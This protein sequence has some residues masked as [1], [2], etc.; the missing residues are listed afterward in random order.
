MSTKFAVVFRD[1]KEEKECMDN[2]KDYLF[3][4]QCAIIFWSTLL[5]LILKKWFMNFQFHFWLDCSLLQYKAFVSQ[6]IFLCPKLSTGI[7]FHLLLKFARP[8]LSNFVTLFQ[9][10]ICSILVPVW[11]CTT[12]QLSYFQN[13]TKDQ[14]LFHTL[15]N[16]KN[17]AL[18]DFSRN[19]G[20]V[21]GE[22]TFC[23]MS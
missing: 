6:T 18:E 5:L 2:V 15:Y 23:T 1:I 17:W 12:L 7:V 8:N 14:V 11:N 4:D 20:E 13:S 19:G 21:C 22:D 16:S 10:G 3:H 9:V